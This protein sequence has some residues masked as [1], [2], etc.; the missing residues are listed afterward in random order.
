M[1]TLLS[2]ALGLACLMAH[3]Q[4][5]VQHPTET[6]ILKAKAVGAKILIDKAYSTLFHAQVFASRLVG[7]SGSPTSACWAMTVIVKHDQEALKRL[8]ESLPYVT[9]PEQKLYVLATMFAFDPKTS[10]RWPLSSFPAS[11]RERKVQ[12]MNGCLHSEASFEEILTEIYH[13][14]SRR[15][16][17]DE[18][19]SIY[20][21]TDVTRDEQKSK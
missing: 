18:R 21:T 5:P 20:Q 10:E 7:E 19:P 14:G 6:E 13:S 3:G 15:Y 16:L 8:T 11:L 17:F 1:K 12:T 4:L 9:V 2:I